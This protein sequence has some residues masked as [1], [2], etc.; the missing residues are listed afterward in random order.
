MAHDQTQPGS[1]SRERRETG[2]EVDSPVNAMRSL[3]A[4]EGKITIFE[5]LHFFLLLDAELYQG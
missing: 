1:F 5:R 3:S 4:H 2:N